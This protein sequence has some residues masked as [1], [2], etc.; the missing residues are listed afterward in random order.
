[1]A[2]IVVGTSNSAHI[3]DRWIGSGIV[4]SGWKH[5]RVL[6]RQFSLSTHS[7]YDVKYVVGARSMYMEYN[8]KVDVPHS[9]SNLKEGT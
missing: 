6:N 1:M 5:N 7:S 2:P 8:A 9:I 3:L 4:S